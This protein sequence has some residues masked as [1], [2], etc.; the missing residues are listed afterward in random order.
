VVRVAFIESLARHSE[1]QRRPRDVRSLLESRQKGDVEASRDRILIRVERHD[2]IFVLQANVL[3]NAIEAAGESEI[4]TFVDDLDSVL[5]GERE[6]RAIVL[7]FLHRIVLVDH[8]VLELVPALSKSVVLLER[9][10][11][12]AGGAEA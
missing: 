10:L 9:L 7:G 8:D 11:E 4:A 12:Y 3:E 1:H 6:H 2:E 5:L